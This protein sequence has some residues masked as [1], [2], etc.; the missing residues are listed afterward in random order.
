M[1]IFRDTHR[2]EMTITAQGNAWLVKMLAFVPDRLY[3]TVYLMREVSTR[4]EAILAMRRAWQRMF[5]E[6]EPL[7]WRDPELSFTA[8]IPRRP[9]R[10]EGR[11]S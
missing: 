2:F 10:T 5:P 9:R 6:D 7:S 4:E 3:P 11:E 8:S 1:V